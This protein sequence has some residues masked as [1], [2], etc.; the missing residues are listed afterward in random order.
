MNVVNVESPIVS[1]DDVPLDRL[2]AAGDDP[3]LL[4]ALHRVVDAAAH[5][6]DNA[7]AAFNNRI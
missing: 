3:A 6:G 7:I 2:R 4:R 1:L 5:I